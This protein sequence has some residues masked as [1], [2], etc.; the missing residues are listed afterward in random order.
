MA[1]DGYAKELEVRN[2]NEVVWTFFTRLSSACTDIEPMYIFSATML[3]KLI[4]KLDSQIPPYNVWNDTTKTAT[5][6]ISATQE[7]KYRLLRGESL[8]KRVERVRQHVGWI[9]KD[10]FDKELPIFSAVS[11]LKD[12]NNVNEY[13]VRGKFLCVEKNVR[14]LY[15]MLS[16]LGETGMPKVL[17]GHYKGTVG[18]G[19]TYE[20]V[21]EVVLPFKALK[22]LLD[23]KFA[24]LLDF[25]SVI[26]YDYAGCEEQAYALSE[27][28]LNS[29]ILKAKNLNSATLSTVQLPS[30]D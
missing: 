17:D 11:I 6:E 23:N 13:L 27:E 22:F 16:L 21:K 29:F 14:I 5:A 8:R 7:L 20:L 2:G 15:A 28:M 4:S 25:S 1:V 10:I 12:G 19:A 26:D 9:D 18:Q 3:R 30:A 24:L